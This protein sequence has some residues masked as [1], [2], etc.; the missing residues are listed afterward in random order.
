METEA[1]YAESTLPANVT[2]CPAEQKVL[3]VP[4][5]IANDQLV[6]SLGAMLEGATIVAPT[7]RA[8]ISLIG[9]IYDPLGFLSPV[10]VRFKILMQELCKHRLGWDQ[11]LDGELLDKWT[12][13]IQQLNEA[14][15][16]ILPRC[17]LQGPSSE[18]KS[19]RLLGFCDA[20]ISAYAAVVYFVEENEGGIYSHFIVSKT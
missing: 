9:R 20:S 16:V 13:L 14:P 4:W 1:T 12:S 17:C 18:S 10:T 7:K 2:K 6:F 15:P 3:G 11:P 5:D 19:Y 8:V